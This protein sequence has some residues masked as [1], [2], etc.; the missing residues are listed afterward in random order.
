LPRIFHNPQ[1]DPLNPDTWPGLLRYRD[2]C[3]DPSRNYPGLLP[4][5]LTGFRDAVARGQIAKPLQYGE[6][7]F[8]W[9][10]EYILKLRCEGIPA[11]KGAQLQPV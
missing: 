5:T 2:I 8:C 6:K 1:L 3:K 4:L 9:T 10:K 11:K 7:T